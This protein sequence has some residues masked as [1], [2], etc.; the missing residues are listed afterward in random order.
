[1]TPPGGYFVK[2][3]IFEYNYSMLSSRLLQNL[4]LALLVVILGAGVG[5]AALIGSRG[6]KS[7]II[8]K[9]VQTIRTGLNYFLQDQNRYPTAVEFQDRNI[10]ENYFSAFPLVNIPGG[11]CQQTYNYFNNTPKTYT[12][13]FCLP[14]GSQGFAAGGNKVGAN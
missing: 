4:F 8:L 13:N 14:K 1:M 3:A 9:N 2:T 10:M 5:F 6:A 12:L 11:S 7:A